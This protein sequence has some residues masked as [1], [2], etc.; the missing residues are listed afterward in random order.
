MQGEAQQVLGQR[1]V[2]GRG[3]GIGLLDDAGDEAILGEAPGLDQTA[4]HPE[5]ATAGRGLEIAGLIAVLVED[6]ADIDALDQILAALDVMGEIVET[7]LDVDFAHVV[8]GQPDPVERNVPRPRELDHREGGFLFLGSSCHHGISATD[9]ES[10]SLD[11]KSVTKR[12]AA[13][14]L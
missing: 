12:S 7:G 14:F 9:A 1:V 10:L 11:T 13:L 3:L 8:G 4:D 6:G 5:A 2:D